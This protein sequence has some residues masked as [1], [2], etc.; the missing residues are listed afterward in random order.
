MSGGGQFCNTGILGYDTFR[1][2]LRVDGTDLTPF[3]VRLDDFQ[4]DFEPTGQAESFRGRLSYQSAEDVEAGVDFGELGD[5][6]AKLLQ[7]SGRHLVM[8]STLGTEFDAGGIF[9]VFSDSTSGAEVTALWAGRAW[10]STS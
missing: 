6:I 3:C 5:G 9:G 10:P 8:E 2:G 1:A 7:R 4:A